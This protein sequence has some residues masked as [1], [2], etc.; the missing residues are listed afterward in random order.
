MIV[1]IDED[2]KPLLTVL[3]GGKTDDDNGGV[4]M[5][6]AGFLASLAAVGALVFLHC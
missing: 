4:R 1:R 6:L 2:A 3:T 5:M